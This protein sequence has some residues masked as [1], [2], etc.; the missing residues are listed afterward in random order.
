MLIEEF[1]LDFKVA[2]ES[3]SPEGW[4]LLYYSSTYQ[5]SFMRRSSK[6]EINWATIISLVSYMYWLQFPR[7]TL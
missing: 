6:P 5:Q 1:P 7:L 3:I 2:A 4:R